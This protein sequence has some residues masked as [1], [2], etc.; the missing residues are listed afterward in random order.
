MKPKNL[1]PKELT[2][3][4][5]LV[6]DEA[7][8][9]YSLNG[10]LVPDLPQV[11]GDYYLEKTRGTQT[12]SKL[13]LF[14]KCPFS[15]FLKYVLELDLGDKS[16]E[17]HFMI[18]DAVDY[19]VSYGE[20]AFYKKYLIVGSDDNF[21]R[22]KNGSVWL[23]DDL[24]LLEK[25][26]AFRLSEL[27]QK[28]IKYPNR[29]TKGDEEEIAKLESTVS[30]AKKAKDKNLLFGVERDIVLKIIE[31]VKRQPLFGLNKKTYNTQV[32]IKAEYKGLM[33]SGTLDR[34]DEENNIIRDTKTIADKLNQKFR[35]TCNFSIQEYGYDF[36]TA[37]YEFLRWAHNKADG[38]EVRSEV[39]L[40]FF[41]KSESC[42]YLAYR[43]PT[44][45]LNEQRQEIMKTLEFLIECIE[46]KHFPTGD[47]LNNFDDSFLNL[48]YYQ[49][50]P[51]TIQKNLI[52]YQPYDLDH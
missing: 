30:F 14:R 28:R 11:E 19:Y 43:M 3:R 36:S 34:E 37:F 13:K 41:G 7:S 52:D 4:W 39:I 38:K 29:G 46:E 42:R 20:S 18:G 6:I 32:K 15:Y 9:Q 44:E 16:E 1:I 17:S 26:L 47:T 22:P 8:G 5:G 50:N 33:V 45:I 49:H 23:D 12:A 10:L 21:I 48:P 35:R 2:E 27:Q 31:E 51:G 40:D 24:V 25:E